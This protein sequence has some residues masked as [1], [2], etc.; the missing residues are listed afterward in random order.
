MTRARQT[1][2]IGLLVSS[3]RF[4]ARAEQS[5]C[6]VLCYCADTRAVIPRPLLAARSLGPKD[7]GPDRPGRM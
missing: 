3:V 1:I 5:R 2:S 6:R 4:S 7:P